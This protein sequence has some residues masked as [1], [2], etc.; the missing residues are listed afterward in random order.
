M[1][2]PPPPRPPRR[3]VWLIRPVFPRAI[4]L[5]APQYPDESKGWPGT[6]PPYSA[7]DVTCHIVPDNGEKRHS[8]VATGWLVEAAGTTTM[9]YVLIVR[10]PSV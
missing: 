4:A 3:T 8:P 2:Y 1:P 5:A 7:V 9:F 6:S 10:L